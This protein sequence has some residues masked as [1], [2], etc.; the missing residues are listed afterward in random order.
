MGRHASDEITELATRSIDAI[1]TYLGPK[2]YFFGDQPTGVD[3]TMFSFVASAMCPVFETPRR[4]AA[5][6][7][8]NLKRYVG[9]MTA[10]YY[11]GLGEVAG[12]MAAA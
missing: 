2:P 6:R 10:R 12:C 8:D 4:K 7:H 3:A 5:E 11:P 9:R 1:A